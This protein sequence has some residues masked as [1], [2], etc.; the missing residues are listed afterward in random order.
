MGNLMQLRRR[1][2]ND[3]PKQMTLTGDLVH[4]ETDMSGTM[5][6]NGSGTITRTGYNVFNERLQLGILNDDGTVSSSE[7]RMVSDLIPVVPGK[8]Y[9][10]SNAISSNTHSGRGAFYDANGDLVLYMPDLPASEHQSDKRYYGTFTVPNDARFLRYC[11][12]TR[13]GTTYK[14]DISINYPAT[15]IYYHPYDGATYTGT[16]GKTL[17]GIN[18][19]WSDS[20]NVTVSYWVHQI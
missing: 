13:Y 3:A 10:Y 14:N 6:I 7:T 17:K 1:M 16:I 5:Q 9:M 18:N 15:E 19:V 8:T 4:F 20:G 12:N 11:T 2:M